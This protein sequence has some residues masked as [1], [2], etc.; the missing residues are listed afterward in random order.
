[1]LKNFERVLHIMEM[2]VVNFCSEV[3]TIWQKALLFNV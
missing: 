3:K 2:C 1:M